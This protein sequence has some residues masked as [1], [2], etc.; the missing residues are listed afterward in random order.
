I[1]LDGKMYFGRN[2]LAGE[3][4][5]MLRSLHFSDAYHYLAKTPE[6][7]TELTAKQMLPI[8]LSFDPEAIAF[9]NPMVS[10]TDDI[11][12]IW[13]KYLPKRLHP[14]LIKVDDEIEYMF[15]GAMLIG[16]AFIDT[17]KVEFE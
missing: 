13:S 10:S 2:H 16:R 3:I 15:W 17:N 11:K 1:I 5:Y 4:H 9:Y 12:E 7:Q 8:I 6:G 14:Q